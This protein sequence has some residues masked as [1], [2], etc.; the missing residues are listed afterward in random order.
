MWGGLMYFSVTV[1]LAHLV[2][3][4]HGE[5]AVKRQDDPVARVRGVGL[6]CLQDGGDLCNSAQEQQQVSTLL[7]GVRVVD[8]L[9]DTQVGPG[10]QLLR[11]RGLLLLGNGLVDHLR[12]HTR[13]HEVRDEQNIGLN[14]LRS[15]SYLIL[16]LY[17]NTCHQKSQSKSQ[18]EVVCKY[19]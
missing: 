16:V 14:P 17:V 5:G 3:V 18:S 4:C 9:Q 12:S 10:V 13:Q 2:L 11:A 6:R 15:R 19:M 1:F 7:G 8:P